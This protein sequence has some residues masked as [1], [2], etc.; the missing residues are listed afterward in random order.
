MRKRRN[1]VFETSS[2]LRRT[3][4]IKMK[5]LILIALAL[6]LSMVLVPSVAAATYPLEVTKV[7]DGPAEDFTFEAW[8]DMNNNGIIDF[9]DPVFGPDLFGGQVVIT[10]S[11][12]DIICVPWLGLYIVREILIADSVYGQPPDQIGK[13]EKLP[14]YFYNEKTGVDA[15][16]SISPWEATNVIGDDHVLTAT[17][18]VRIVV[19]SP[20][21]LVV[22]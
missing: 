2:E 11:G 12:T 5:R 10:G 6:A 4:R 7:A 13:P 16:I 19:A 1:T 8:R 21:V 15:R 14:V 17:V 3:R 18:E 20:A 22:F 9:D